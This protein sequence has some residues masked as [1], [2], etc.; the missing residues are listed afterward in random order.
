MFFRIPLCL[1]AIS[2]FSSAATIPQHGASKSHQSAKV[3]R[4]GACTHGPLTRNCW[5]DG[6][7]IATEYDEKT[8][9]TGQTRTYNLEI[10]NTTADPDG[11]GARLAMLVNG[12]Y[13][14]PPIIAD[15]G[16]ILVIN[17][18][19]SLQDNGTSMHWHGIRQLNSNQYDGTNG[20][21]ECPIAPGHTKTYTFK[22]TQ[23]GTSWYHSHHSVQ[24]GDGVMGTIIINGPA[25]ANYD[26]DLG[27][28]PIT[29]YFYLP[30]FE[31]NERAQ[32]SLTG[33][34]IAD[35]ILINGTM[36]NA[37]GG[38]NYF[39]MTVTKGKKYRLRLINTSVNS[40]L[41]VSMDGHPFTVIASDL[42]PVVPYGTDQ[43]A[44]NMGQRY[45]VIIETNQNCDNYWFRVGVAAECSENKMT[46][47]TI[48]IGAIL[49]YDEAVDAEPT[50][51]GVILKTTCDDETNLVPYVAIDVPSAPLLSTLKEISLDLSGKDAQNN[52]VRWL[53][54][55]SAMEVNWEKPILQYALDGDTNYPPNSN[56][57][58]MP[59]A[60]AWYYW[61][62]QSV[63]TNPVQIPH[64][65]HL[66][67]HDFS[68]V[69]VGD[70]VWDGSTTGFSFTNPTRRD[71][72][73][74]PAGGYL[75]LAF[76]ANNPGAWLM[77]CHVA[78]HASQGLS[79]GFLER[80]DEI[81]DAIG[82]VT[83]FTEGCAAWTSWWN[84]D[85]AYKLT[86]SGV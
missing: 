19:N 54:N 34:P 39:K 21:T 35:N 10:T 12:V 5:S 48:Q 60:N 68:I 61:W 31:I 11:H 26:Y 13:P 64:P 17:V 9:S 58:E 71:V 62:I 42:V 47:S 81:K 20:A 84:G 82:D 24:Y 83:S 67:G 25:T 4:D 7:S 80:K 43:L 55:G 23:Y 18:K 86:D 28:L 79:M 56:I 38:G 57:F 40:F 59:T 51:T 15:W 16:D 14:G 70:D 76:P 66:H 2:S 29:D 65:I 85:H 33:P 6:F 74:L 27:T 77:H 49:H 45:D 41:H 52:L 22:A 8:P 46:N 30:A 72:A 73:T 78:W 69:A 44:I 50:S 1:L 63:S 3:G 75:I 37:N 36:K 32:H 53:I